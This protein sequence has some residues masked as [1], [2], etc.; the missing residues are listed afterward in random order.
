MPRTSWRTDSSKPNRSRPGLGRI[1][2]DNE[3]SGSRLGHE[4]YASLLDHQDPNGREECPLGRRAE[5]ALQV[6]FEVSVAISSR[7]ARKH[8]A[9]AKV[10]P[11]SSGSSDAMLRSR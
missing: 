11:R 10:A 7:L 4:N 2:R 5:S 3:C 9:I 8:G 1:S 6:S